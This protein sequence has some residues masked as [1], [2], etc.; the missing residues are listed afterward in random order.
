MA[1]A[2]RLPYEADSF[3][4]VVIANALHVMPEP[5]KALAEIRRVLKPGGLLLAP[6]FVHGEGS[7]FRLRV[8]LMELAGFHTYFRWSA[9]EFAS[10]VTDRG[11]V[12]E[13]CDLMNGGVTP[14]CYLE[15][16]SAEKRA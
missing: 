2:T 12:V 14:L 13:T 6:T 8:R 16:R 10:F 4:A 11:F 1:D 5:E 15:A 9:K 3:D 7:G